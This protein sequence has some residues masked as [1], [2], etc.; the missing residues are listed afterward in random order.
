MGSK[1]I[2]E[3]TL[4]KIALHERMAARQ[5]KY[6]QFV[7]RVNE[8]I[9]HTDVVPKFGETSVDQSTLSDLVTSIVSPAD[10]MT[11]RSEDNLEALISC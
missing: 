9:W 6:R 5:Q 11:L 1:Q 3:H 4:G 10:P 7:R 8:A 2:S